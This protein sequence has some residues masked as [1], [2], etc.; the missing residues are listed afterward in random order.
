MN[1]MFYTEWQ[2]GVGFLLICNIKIIDINKVCIGYSVYLQS[3]QPPVLTGHSNT[4]LFCSKG[5]LVSHPPHTGG[6]MGHFFMCSFMH[7]KLLQRLSANKRQLLQ[8]IINIT[9]DYFK[10]QDSRSLFYAIMYKI[11]KKQKIT[12]ANW[13]K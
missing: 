13:M 9:K 2:F 3:W 5:V 12:Y 8:F 6:S 7:H 11:R 10:I 4:L 1:L